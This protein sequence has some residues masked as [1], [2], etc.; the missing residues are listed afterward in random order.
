M[1]P[2]SLFLKNGLNCFLDELASLSFSKSTIFFDIFYTILTTFSNSLEC[3]SLGLVSNKGFLLLKVLVSD[4]IVCLFIISSSTSTFWLLHKFLP[5]K[6]LLNAEQ[7]LLCQGKVLKY[8]IP[9][10]FLQQ[11]LRQH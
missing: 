6:D 7:T 3:S 10:K 4:S 5:K 11:V 1:A 8:N 9:L 2:S